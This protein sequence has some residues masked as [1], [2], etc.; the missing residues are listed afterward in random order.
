MVEVF[1]RDRRR[2][3]RSVQPWR[4]GAPRIFLP[5]NVLD[6]GSRDFLGLVHDMTR[7]DAPTDRYAL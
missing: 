4:E 2:S 6:C 1:R 3:A 5:S 7:W